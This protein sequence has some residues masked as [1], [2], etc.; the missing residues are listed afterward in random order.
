MSYIPQA[1]AFFHFG[2]QPAITP[3]GMENSSRIVGGEESVSGQNFCG[4][5]KFDIQLQ[6]PL[7]AMLVQPSSPYEVSAISIPVT[8]TDSPFARSPGLVECFFLHS[9]NPLG[10]I[11]GWIADYTYSLPSTIVHICDEN[12]NIGTLDFS[13]MLKVTDFIGELTI[14]DMF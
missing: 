10:Q 13:E 6:Q 11:H 1:S 2:G 9:L 7:W 5:H 4:V 8:L 12:W 3:T 14:T